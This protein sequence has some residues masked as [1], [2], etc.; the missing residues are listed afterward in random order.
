MAGEEQAGGSASAASGLSHEQRDRP[1]HRRTH[2]RGEGAGLRTRAAS[3]TSRTQPI[4][5]AKCN[6]CHRGAKA[7][8]DLRLDSLAEAAS[9]IKPGHP[10]ASELIARIVTDDEDEI[11]PPKGKPLTKSEI[12]AYAMDQGGRALARH[13]RRPPDAH[14]TR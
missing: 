5:E 2:C 14:G 8:G 1:L 12:A 4:L 13:P 9:A 6:E 11:M 10:D 3:T 7:K